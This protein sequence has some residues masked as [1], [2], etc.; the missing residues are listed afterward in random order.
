MKYFLAK[1]GMTGPH[2]HPGKKDDTRFCDRSPRA[3]EPTHARRFLVLLPFGRPRPGRCRS[4]CPHHPTVNAFDPGDGGF[5]RVVIFD[6]PLCRLADP[7][8]LL[9]MPD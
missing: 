1:A 4:S 6:E 3:S 2:R 7:G 5:E 9:G 8:S